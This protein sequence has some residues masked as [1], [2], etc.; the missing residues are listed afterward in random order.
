MDMPVT[1]IGRATA[2]LLLQLVLVT[3][4]AFIL[5][6]ISPIEPLNYYIGD[7]MMSVSNEQRLLLAQNLGLDQSIS[8]RF[9]IWGQH[10]LQGDLGFSI[11][12][13]QP[14]IDVIIERFLS[15]LLLMGND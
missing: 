12:F 15:S 8:E 14:V 7:Q 5:L 9:I 3:L 10:L 2:R 4:F 13:H 11:K 1:I 6:A